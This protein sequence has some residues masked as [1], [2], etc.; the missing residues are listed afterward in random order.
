M[1]KTEKNNLVKIFFIILFI[2]NL[3]LMVVKDGYTFLPER[4]SFD[5]TIRLLIP[6]IFY[7]RMESLQ[8]VSMSEN[9]K[10]DLVLLLLFTLTYVVYL[11][12]M[13]TFLF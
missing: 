5:S 4:L 1:E 11:A 8:I 3:I 13:I 6:V 10:I 7:P 2:G 12:K 9:K